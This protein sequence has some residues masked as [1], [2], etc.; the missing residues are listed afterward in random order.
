MADNINTT[1]NDETVQIELSTQEP[2]DTTQEKL[3]MKILRDY[4]ETEHDGLMTLSNTDSTQDVLYPVTRVENVV[5]STGKSLDTI[6]SEIQTNFNSTMA[7][8]ITAILKE[9][10]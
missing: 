9:G 4:N 10:Y 5:D 2:T 1:T 3:Y 7:A 8:E 6:L